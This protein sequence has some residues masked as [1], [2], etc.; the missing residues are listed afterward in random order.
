MVRGSSTWNFEGESCQLQQRWSLKKVVSHRDGLPT[1]FPLYQLHH[2]CTWL[3]I[4]FGFS[5]HI[6]QQ[7]REGCVILTV[8][9]FS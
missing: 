9:V 2:S 5:V 8:P 1:G 3:A 7:E 4:Q 6:C